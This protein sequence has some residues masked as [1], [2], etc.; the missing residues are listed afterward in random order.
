M[1]KAKTSSVLPPGGVGVDGCVGLGEVGTEVNVSSSGN[2]CV[3]G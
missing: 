1:E 2:T 3:F